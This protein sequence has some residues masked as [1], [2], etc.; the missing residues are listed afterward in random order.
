MRFFLLS[1]LLLSVFIAQT[2]F[3]PNFLIS[4]AIPNILFVILIF[5]AFG[6]FDFRE[7]MALA[8]FTGILLSVYSGSAFGAD[9]LAV[10]ASVYLVNFLAYNFFGKENFFVFCAGVAV[11]SV[12]YK[13]FYFGVLKSYELS[14]IA[15][16]S[17]PILKLIAQVSAISVVVNVFSAAIL[18]PFLKKAIS[19]IQNNK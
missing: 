18:Y 11:G 8:F 14:G 7:L 17:V 6:R 12:F 13:I 15:P 5:F 2:G 4:S 19:L 16:I 10:L 9:L 3:L 1:L